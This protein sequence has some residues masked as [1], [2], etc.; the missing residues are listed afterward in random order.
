V[1]RECYRFLQ[2]VLEFS[3][4]IPDDLFVGGGIFAQELGEVVNRALT[5]AGAPNGGSGGAEDVGFVGGGVVD[6]GFDGYGLDD[7]P[8]VASDGENVRH[9]TSYAVEF[10]GQV[11]LLHRVMCK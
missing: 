8:V 1:G 2:E 9:G 4:G 5:V 7:E 11:T 3:E 6:D 10:T